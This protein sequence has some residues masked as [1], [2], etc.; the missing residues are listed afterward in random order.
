[1]DGRSTSGRKARGRRDA[2]RQLE[3]DGGAVRA[4][5]EGTGSLFELR[6]VGV[7]EGHA[8]IRG[9]IDAEGVLFED[10]PVPVDEL[11]RLGWRYHKRDGWER[12]W[13]LRSDLDRTDLESAAHATVAIL[14]AL[15]DQDTGSY[16]FVYRPPGEED[17][18]YAQ[19]GCLFAAVSAFVGDILGL[20]VTAVRNEPVPLIEMSVFAGSVGFLAGFLA[21]GIAFP[22]LLAIIG[23]FRGR[24]ADTTTWLMV[25]V[26]GLIVLS[27]WLLAPRFGPLNGDQLLGVAAALFV[28]VLVW[29]FIPLIAVLV[30]RQRM[31][32]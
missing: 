17:A 5:K 8:E 7:R 31:R 29:G 16:A 12:R 30:R 20:I 11:T 21:F 19:V 1:M 26:P 14:A 25:V 28:A 27:I 23:A 13:V 32:R 24:A 22:R 10:R 9:H 3:R 18:G 15:H 4:F 6:H 2:F